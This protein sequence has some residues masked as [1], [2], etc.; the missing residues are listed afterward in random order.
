MPAT[1]APIMMVIRIGVPVSWLTT[2]SPRGS[3]WSRLIANN[4]RVAPVISVITTVVSPA[5][6]PAAMIVPTVSWP[7]LVN[8]LAK[9]A[10]VS[11]SL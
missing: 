11:M 6:A 4:T 10:S 1:V 7:A 2:P 3:R 5:T 8:A 9:A